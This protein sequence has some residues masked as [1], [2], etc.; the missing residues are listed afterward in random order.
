MVDTVLLF[1]PKYPPSGGGAA[2]FY[3]NLVETQAGEIEFF[4]VTEYDRDEAIVT[5]DGQ[6]TLYRVLPRFDWLPRFVRVPLEVLVL[7]LMASYTILTKGV[8][9]IHAHASSFAVLGLA[10]AATVF[11]VPIVNDCRDEG[12][13]PWIVKAGPTPVWFSC[14]SNIDEMLVENGVPDG[15]IVRLPVVNPEHVH[16]YRIAEREHGITDIA[17]VGTVRKEKGVFMLIDAFELIRDHGL[18]ARLTMI[19]D[20]PAVDELSEYV[21]RRGLADHVTLAGRLDHHETLRRLAD[22]DVLVLPSASEGLPR[23]VLEAQEVGTPVVA[24]MVGGVPDGIED[25]ESG[26]LV[27]RTPESIS[28]SILRM[29]RDDDLYF[30]IIENGLAAADERGWDQ[31]GVQLREGYERATGQSA[32]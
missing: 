1:T 8:D 3:S 5:R 6:V 27:D 10:I 29:A 26:I 19:G 28:D 20:G 22:A 18:D 15:R 13:R 23:V 25:G 16:E 12:F 17:F 14:A 32:A 2:V 30:R 24:T 21:R 4:G 31:L 11:R 7:F 9:L